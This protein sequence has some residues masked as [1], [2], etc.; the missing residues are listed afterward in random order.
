M[1]SHVASLIHAALRRLPAAR[2]VYAQRDALAAVVGQRDDA[3]HG[4]RER[5]RAL[6]A[7]VEATRAAP[8]PPAEDPLARFA[9]WVRDGAFAQV[10]G[11]L[12]TLR[13]DGL[14]GAAGSQLAFPFDGNMFPATVLNGGW[15]AEELDFLSAHVD[16]SQTY[17]LLDIGANIGLF[18][19]QAAR[20]LPNLGRVVC[21]EAD[22]GNFAALNFNLAHLP[23]PLRALHNIALADR[24]GELT[25]YRDANNIGNYSLNADAMRG[26][27]HHAVTIGAVD[28]RDFLSGDLGFAPSQR[29]IWKS[30]TQG[31]DEL[32]IS[33]APDPLW[34]RVDLAVVELWRIAKPAFD[35]DAFQRRIGAFANMTIGTHRRVTPQEVMAYLDG[36]DY[37]HDDLYLWR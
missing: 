6:Q 26:Q 12:L 15:Q 18:S 13:N 1:R 33:R 36:D 10:S 30:D 11:H 23:P 5:V 4:L 8:P 25:W 19:R 31:F 21:V 35:R 14:L 7:E 24:A 22:P 17:G 20:R 28:A 2:N 32:I 34:D 29:L 16:P 37:A 9:Q 3:L 27:A